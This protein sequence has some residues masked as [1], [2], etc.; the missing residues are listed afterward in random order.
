VL[1]EAGQDRVR[2]A[3]L[4]GISRSSLYRKMEQLGIALD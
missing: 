1:R 4:L 3:K 2:A